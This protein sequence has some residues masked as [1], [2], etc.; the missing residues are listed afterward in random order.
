KTREDNKKNKNIILYEGL[1]NF[2]IYGPRSPFTNVLSNKELAALTPDDLLPIIRSLTTTEHK[3]LYYGP[4]TQ[5]ELLADLNTHH[6]LPD[7]LQPAPAPVE[8]S[9]PDIVKPVVYWTD[10]D[11]VQAEIAMHAKGPVFDPA[12]APQSRM[13]NE[14]FGGNMSSIVFQ[15]IREAQGLAYAVSASYTHPA[16]AGDHDRLFAYVGT[17]AD[18]QA[19]AMAALIKI[20]NEMPESE[21][22]LEAARKSILNQIESER[23]VRT[24]VLF[25]Y[26]NAK[27]RGLEYDLRKDVYEK[28]PSLSLTDVKQF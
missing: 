7:Q 11:M 1:L 26:L 16:K 12:V 17:Q 19:E 4:S 10:Y 5:E 21:S 22:T 3:V 9:M 20:M 6:L 13:Y 24:S 18:K 15:E 25:N 28:V 27:K 23:I 8:F 14:Y 2:G